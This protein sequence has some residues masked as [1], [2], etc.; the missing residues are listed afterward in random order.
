MINF[1]LPEFYYKYNLN[2]TF[3][4]LFKSNPELFY[5]DI[6]IRSVY[7]C[8]PVSIWNGGRV[9][10]GTCSLENMR[11]TI[12]S[13][14]DLGVG[15]RYTFTNCLLEENDVYD[16][17][18]NMQMKLIHD[19]NYNLDT[20]LNEVLVNSNILSKYLA[21]KYPLVPQISSTTKRLTKIDDVMHEMIQ[22]Y[23]LVVLDY[24]Y[25]NSDQLFESPLN[26]NTEMFEILLNAYCQDFCPARSRHYEQLSK[27][28]LNY[29][30][31]T[32]DFSACCHIGDDF[33]D[34]LETRGKIITVEDLYTRYKDAG[35]QH[36]KIE[37]RTNSPF[38]VLESYLYYMIKPENH[39]KMRLKILNSVY[40]G[41]V[42]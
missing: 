17:F 2:I 7:G 12:K 5:D 27:Q 8:F 24:N 35:Y 33:Y 25:N 29:M 1:Y 36:F 34:V 23:K 28:Q 32:P 41:I 37:G 18:C 15:I 14:N 38:D 16:R 30:E 40:G 22:G 6:N 13:F 9:M 4:N 31:D 10:Q 20:D 39:D 3:I 26:M 11:N 21:E 19:A 42:R